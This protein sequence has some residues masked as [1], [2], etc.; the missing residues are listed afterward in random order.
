MIAKFIGKNTV[1]QYGFA[2]QI[3]S[4]AMMMIGTSIVLTL[5]PHA[6]EAHNNNN[7]QQRNLFFIKMFKYG[8]YLSIGFYIIISLTATWF[9]NLLDISEYHNVPAYLMILGIFPFF[10]HLYN[11]S[12]HYLQLMKIFYIQVYI[13][14]VVMLENLVLNYFM[15]QKY[16]VVGAAYASLISYITLAVIYGYLV[17]KYK[18]QKLEKG[19]L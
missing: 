9:I 4:I 2:S 1:A 3:I 19:N 17:I 11:V 7:I 15:I 16:S 14:I 13:A 6:T 10:Q 8:I 18:I 5:F 12:S